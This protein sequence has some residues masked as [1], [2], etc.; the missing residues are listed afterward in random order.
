MGVA[1][2]E[3]G[4]AGVQGN[5]LLNFPPEDNLM[6]IGRM[7]LAV[8]ITLAFPMLALPC[9]DTLLRML[10]SSTSEDLKKPLLEDGDEE[11]LDDDESGRGYNEGGSGYFMKKLFVTL[12]IFWSAL[13]VACNVDSIT[14]VWDVLGSSISIL[15]IFI[16]P[17]ASYL[18][19]SDRRRRRCLSILRGSEADYSKGGYA[20][21]LDEEGV[22]EGSELVEDDDLVLGQADESEVYE[23]L[24]GRK[25]S[26]NNNIAYKVMKV[27]EN[28]TRR[29][30][31]AWLVVTSSS[32]L[33]VFCSINAIRNLVN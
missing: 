20:E 22:T 17:S 7:C 29:Q 26:M 16:L 5:V 3:Y 27:V 30:A 2:C 13:A 8:T 25:S 1:N 33:M 9:R 31:F 12:A 32:A 21:L 14:V 23:S 15:A 11:G 4:G 19:V 6:T 10:V 18:I 28:I 24:G